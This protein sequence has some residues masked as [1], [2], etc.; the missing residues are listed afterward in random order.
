LKDPL[1]LQ[2]SSQTYDLL[3]AQVNWLWEKADLTFKVGA[4]NLLN[5][6]QFQA[7]GG[8]R[9]GRLAYASILYEFQKQ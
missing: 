4:S 6:M 8:P 3:D 1:S 7:Y 9:I 2:D 5:N